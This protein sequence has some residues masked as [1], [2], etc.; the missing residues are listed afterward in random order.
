MCVYV[1]EVGGAAPCPVLPWLCCATAAWHPPLRSQWPQSWCCDVTSKRR[2]QWYPIGCSRPY[3][4]FISWFQMLTLLGRAWKIVYRLIILLLS[5]EIF[6]KRRKIYSMW[7]ETRDTRATGAKLFRVKKIYTV[8]V[9]TSVTESSQNWPAWSFRELVDSQF[10]AQA[11]LET[12][13]ARPS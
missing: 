9:L 2:P 4:G 6:S 13:V 10:S 11:M 1:V 8:S 5:T 12:L 7:R 3:E